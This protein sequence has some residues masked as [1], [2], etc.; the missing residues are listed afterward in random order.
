[1]PE[2]ACDDTDGSDFAVVE[3]CGERHRVRPGQTFVLGREGDLVLDEN[4]YLHRR[5]LEL[6]NATGIWW[7]C[8]VGSRL[9]ATVTDRAGTMQAWLAPYARLPLVGQAS[10]WFTAGPTTYLLSIEVPSPGIE[11]VSVPASDFGSGTTTLGRIILTTDQR[12]L[13]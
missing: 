8:N 9:S 11:A 3:F 5:F 10:I 4:P 2:C 6:T 12:R 7:L 13:S 1:M